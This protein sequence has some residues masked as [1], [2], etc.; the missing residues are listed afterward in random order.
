MDR[1]FTS[2]LPYRVHPLYLLFHR[3]CS[4]KA[5]LTVPYAPAYYTL[6]AQSVNVHFR[7]VLQLTKAIQ[8]TLKGRNIKTKMTAFGRPRPTQFKSNSK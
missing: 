2:H 8:R 3:L 7:S 4:A 1:C 6:I 5:Q